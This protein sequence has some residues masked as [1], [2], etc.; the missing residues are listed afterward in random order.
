MRAM[1]DS[2]VEWIGKIPKAWT[3]CRIKN[4]ANVL[5]GGSPRPIEEY[6]TDEPDGLNWIKIGDTEKGEKYITHTSQK[7]SSRGLSKT[8]L[9]HSGDLLL[10]NSMS[11]GEPYILGIE[12]CIHD[13]WVCFTNVHSISQEYLYYV[14]C[15]D[16]CKTQF[17]LQV[18][19]G[20]VQNLNIDKIGATFVVLPPLTEQTAIAAYLDDKCSKIDNNIRLREALIAKLLDYK[21]SLIYETVT[22]KKETV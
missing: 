17:R 15:S 14:L 13:G 18:A 7:I 3:I 20:V 22:G 4:V 11:F 9:V 16:L 6:L 2:G 21:K 19:G 10:T 5:R 12:G 8:R 1:K